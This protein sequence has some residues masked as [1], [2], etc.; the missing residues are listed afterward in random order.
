MATMSGRSKTIKASSVSPTM[1]RRSLG[2]MPL[3]TS[4]AR[5]KSSKGKKLAASLDA[6][7]TRKS[8][9]ITNWDTGKLESEYIRN[10]QQQVM[11]GEL[12][13][14]SQDLI[15]KESQVSIALEERDLAMEKL[16]KHEDSFAL[17]KKDLVNEVVRLKK[18]L[19]RQQMDTSR[20]EVHISEIRREA[21]MG[22]SALQEAE[23]KIN[24]YRREADG[25]TED[26]NRLRIQ[27][28]EKRSE[29]LKLQTE[30]QELEERFFK[31][32]TRS[33][34]EI[35]SQLKEEIKLLRYDC[36]QKDISAEQERALR[37]KISDD[38]AALVKENAALSSQ[39]FELRKLLD[40]ERQFQDDKEQRRHANIHELVTAK[41]NEKQLTREVEH[42]KDQLRL[43][44]MKHKDATGKLLEGER[45]LNRAKLRG[46]KLQSEVEELENLNTSQSE[47]NIQLRRDKMI[48]TDHVAD[49]QAQLSE[50]EEEIETAKIELHDYKERL[51]QLDSHM[52]MQRS[53]DSIKWEEFEKMAD[54][55]K[56]FSKHMSPLRHSR[57]VEFDS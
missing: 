51:T 37:N 45:G 28:E 39:V 56:E 49:L 22:L 16:R 7:G 54:S 1:S 27:L 24:T 38:C 36:R 13:V 19:D 33:K 34:D 8:L 14:R 42:L 46:T 32:D 21:D 18:Q 40:A 50:K 3:S 47:E 57:T 17:E 2:T 5:P 6:S 4:N 9:D 26:L 23:N 11:Q 35:A 55:L 52:K 25:K 15:R 20:K 30:Y 53:M 48:L 44:Q 43:E 31:S 29:C 10:L 41:E 12:D